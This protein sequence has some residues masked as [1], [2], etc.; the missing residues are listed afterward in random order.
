MEWLA[1]LIVMVAVFIMV[2]Q[3][4]Y[5]RCVFPSSCGWYLTTVGYD[6]HSVAVKPMSGEKFEAEKK[7]AARAGTVTSG[8]AAKRPEELGQVIDVTPY[9]IDAMSV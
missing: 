2:S 8:H 3:S 1:I 9:L 6:W 7:R 5:E 4:A